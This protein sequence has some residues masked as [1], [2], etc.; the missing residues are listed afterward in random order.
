[1]EKSK[2]LRK[3]KTL[4]GPSRRPGRVAGKARS[5]ARSSCDVVEVKEIRDCP[6]EDANKLWLCIRSRATEDRVSSMPPLSSS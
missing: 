5:P 2:T 3:L 6:R 1:M 4:F